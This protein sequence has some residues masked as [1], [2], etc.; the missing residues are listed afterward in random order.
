M[1]ID[2]SMKDRITGLMQL[3]VRNIKELLEA[4]T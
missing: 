4:E 1:P 3:S 2:E